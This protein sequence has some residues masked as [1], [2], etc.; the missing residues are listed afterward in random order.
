MTS[1]ALEIQRIDSD[2]FVSGDIV[3]QDDLK[4]KAVFE[5]AP[6]K[7][8]ILVNSRGGHLN[9]SLNIA[10]WLTTQPLTT[11]VSGPCLSACSLIF[12]AG[13]ERMYATG[14]EPRLTVIGIHGPSLPLTGQML[15]ERAAEMLAFYKERMGHKYDAQLLH[16]ALYEMKDA[17]GFVL[18]REITRNSPKDRITLHCPTACTPRWQCTEYPRLDAFTLGLVTTTETVSL[19]LPDSMRPRMP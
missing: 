18:V 16:T 6:V 12:M 2:V 19:Q 13:K 11:L 15:P 17:T 5:A 7:R 8:L 14:F 1:H 9:A 3:A 10:R 4:L